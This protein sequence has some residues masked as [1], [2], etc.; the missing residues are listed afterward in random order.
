[1]C[2]NGIAV[3]VKWK[4]LKFSPIG[5]FSMEIWNGSPLVQLNWL[6]NG[7]V[8]IFFWPCSWIHQIT[9]WT[10][11]FSMYSILLVLWTLQIKSMNYKF[12]MMRAWMF[13]YFFFPLKINI[14][15]IVV[16]FF[17]KETEWKKYILVSIKLVIWIS[18]ME[19]FL[20]KLISKL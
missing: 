17:S 20:M 14:K 8:M 3:E 18:Q 10:A 6:F 13:R 1:M 11:F 19:V 9:W 5:F 12:M 4:N 2:W 7:C 15:F 16:F